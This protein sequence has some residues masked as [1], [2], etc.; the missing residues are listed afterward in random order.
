[1]ILVEDSDQCALHEEDLVLVCP[2]CCPQAFT[3]LEEEHSDLEAS[4][5]NR[6]D[7]TIGLL[8]EAL[9][10][11][12]ATLRT[13]MTL[14]LKQAEAAAIRAERARVADEKR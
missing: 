9:T 4:R 5:K 3:H 6:V 7:T 8:L 10:P 14:A 12:W 13:F 1:M 2:S 11:F